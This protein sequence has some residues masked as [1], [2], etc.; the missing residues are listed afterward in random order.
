[1]SEP[2]YTPPPISGY[3]VLAQSDVDLMNEV[4]AAEAAYL[5]VID[6]VAFRVEDQYKAAFDGG[7][8]TQAGAEEIRRIVGANPRRW[9]SIGRTHVEQATMAVCRA[10]AQP[11]R[12]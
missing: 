1:M 8:E 12:P 4:K 10:I 5:A 11:G 2:T 7:N 3:R 9:V 6:R